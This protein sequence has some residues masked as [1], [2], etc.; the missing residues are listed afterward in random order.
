MFAS[1]FIEFSHSL[2][3]DDIPDET[4]AFARRCLLDIV[5]VAAAGSRTE[6][7]RIISNHAVR[8]F[9]ASSEGGSAGLLY[10]AREVSP[11]GA[12]MANG[13][14]ID[15]VDAHDGNKLVKGH[16]G[17]GVFPAVMAMM[18]SQSSN[19]EKEFLT[20]LVIGYELGTRAGM[21][22]HAS[23]CDYHTSGA[24]V[25]VACAAIGA[26]ALGLT[27]QQTRE[28]I[29]I[30]EYHGPRSQ[31]MREIDHPTMVKDGSG[32][33]AMSGVSAAFLAADGF[34]GA[35]AITVEHQDHHALWSSLGSHWMIHEQYFK[36]YPVC[37]WAQP[38]VEAALTLCRAYQLESKDIEHIEVET[39]HEAK[40]LATAN[41]ETTDQAQYS[42]PYPT[43]AAIVYGTLLPE[44]ID[45]SALH[46]LE[47]VRLAS[48]MVLTESD[49]FNAQFPAKRFAKV[50]IVTSDNRRLES[51]PTEARG[52]PEAPLSH[53]EI[54]DKFYAYATPVLG[55]QRALAIEQAIS[56]LGSGEQ[57]DQ[58]FHQILA[59]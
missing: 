44:H 33:G 25:A 15:S 56:C 51:K 11:V 8:Y 58:L 41:P 17:C 43:A 18:Q 21:A 59:G 48:S 53:Q 57:L 47:V 12:A 40:R 42:L 9:A 34:T 52:D 4:I 20:N 22:L 29:G 13:M 31:M 2:T 16:V 49:E 7:S 6:L 5:G 36:P 10:D 55:Q 38:A 54:V 24:W 46:N 14:I 23:A 3:Y 27:A 50:T 32:W 39:F 37:R 45:G 19:D 1:K 28:A 30:A 26:R 35:P